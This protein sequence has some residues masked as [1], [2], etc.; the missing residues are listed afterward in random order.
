LALTRFN[1]AGGGGSNVNLAGKATVVGN[2]VELDFGV[3][4]IGGNRNAAPGDGYY[5]LRVDADGDGLLETRRHFYR[6]L[7]DTN[8]DRV[9]SLAD[10]DAINADLGQTGVRDTD[11]NGD[12]VV[13]ATDANIANAQRGR[14]L[15]SSLPLND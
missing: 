4:G 13:N 2:R 5:R 3:Q 8:H 12:G 10:V 15:A 7:G 11:V 1:L 6:L 14:Q 9:V